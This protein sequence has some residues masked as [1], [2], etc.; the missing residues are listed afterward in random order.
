[1]VNIK[2]YLSFK[3]KNEKHGLR[4]HV[5]V[6][7][8]NKD[9]GKVSLW[10]ESDNIIPISGYQWVLMKMFGLHLDSEHNTSYED[11]GQDSTIV[12]PDLNTY[13]TLE[14][15]VNPQDYTEMVE[16]IAS[17]H[18]VQGFMVGSGGSAEDGN[19][20]YSFIS[21]VKNTDYSYTCLRNP[22][23]FQQT[24]TTLP[25]A[26][27]NKYLGVSRFNDSSNVKSYFIKKFDERPHI[28]H[29]WWRN[30]QEWDYVDPVMP[31]D[32]GPSASSTNPK[33]DRI[34]TYAEIKLSI[35]TSNGDCLSYFDH[36]Q[37]SMAGINEIGLVSFDTLPGTHSIC[38]K[39]NE[40]YISKLV[41][42][43]FDT[44]TFDEKPDLI[45]RDMLSLFNT[46]KY[47]LS[48]PIN[49]E[50]EEPT[51]IGDIL[52]GGSLNNFCTLIDAYAS[53]SA[54]NIRN[55]ITTIRSSLESSI[56]VDARYNQNGTFIYAT[57]N[58]EDQL[59]DYEVL[60]VDEA[61]RI[62]LIT[63]YTFKT[64]PLE[65][66]VRILFNYRIYAN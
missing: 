2:D 27:A 21:S 38:V 58:F 5:S 12:I 25:K 1:M 65:S 4:G 32:L 18:I 61:Q 35:D 43:A 49:V 47:G 53:G 23:P 28:Y 7:I 29:S 9:T 66:N 44:K 54:D 59:N 41:A 8:E 51:T 45:A 48:T 6:A 46:I 34:E 33:S 13:S 3:D 36:S 55:D 17:N 64:L 63:Y 52:K 60:T 19:G 56:N 11:M 50:D 31:S 22:I 37:S 10:E 62:K 57:D 40:T 24:Q 39:L 20:D 15:G 16:D 26:L 14:I 42:L 30:D